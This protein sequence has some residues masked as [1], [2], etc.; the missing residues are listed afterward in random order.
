VAILLALYAWFPLIQ[1]RYLVFLSPW[2]FLLVVLGAATAH[3]ALRPLLLGGLVLVIGGGTAMYTAASGAL[4]AE[5]RVRLLD[6]RPV[7]ER[8]VLDP[9]SPIVRFGH[10]HAYAREPW[11]DVYDFVQRFAKPGDVVALH[12]WYVHTVWDYYAA[13]GEEVEGDVAL[14]ALRLPRL[15]ESP[16]EIVARFGERLRSARRVFLVMSRHETEDPDHYYA[17]LLDV[18][19][20]VWGLAELGPV[21]PPIEFRVS[22]GIRVAVFTRS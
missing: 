1:E 14:D 15:E 11:R 20:R 6:D 10:G 16:E 13:R 21:I 7:P 5:G 18:L 4:V 17:V 9:E 19:G 12:P 3:R 2:V 8:F 22:W